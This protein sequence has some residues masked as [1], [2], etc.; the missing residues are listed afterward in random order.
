MKLHNKLY[1]ITIVL[2]IVMLFFPY[3]INA[4]IEYNANGEVNTDVV[5]T[6]IEDDNLVVKIKKSVAFWYYLMRLISISVMLLILLFTGIKMAISTVASEKAMYKRMLTDWVVGMILVFSI[7]YIMVAIINFNEMLV[8]VL[9]NV[10]IGS[11]SESLSKE[12]NLSKYNSAS[13]IEIS[14]YEAVRT[15]AYDA[16]LINGTTGMVMYMFLVYYAVKFTIMYLK[17][18]LT[19]VVL[20]LMAP[21]VSTSYAI[22]KIMTGKSKIFSTWLTEYFMNVII[23]TVHALVY[24]V[25][26]STAIVISL[27]SIS[28]MILALVLL[29]FMSKAEKLF[30][31]IFKLSDSA[32]AND[33]AENTGIKQLTDAFKAGKQ[34]MIGGEIAKGI[35]KVGMKAV[36]KPLKMVGTKAFSA[37]MVARAKLK[38][39]KGDYDSQ[40]NDGTI[41]SVSENDVLEKRIKSKLDQKESIDKN[42]E[43]IE[44]DLEDANKKRANNEE[45]QERY[46]E[47]LK[48]K[49]E[50]EKKKKKVDG[51]IAVLESDQIRVRDV[52]KAK[53][54]NLLDPRHYVENRRGKLRAK[55]R[56][57]QWVT[58]KVFA[59]E[60]KSNKQG[61]GAIL[62]EQLSAQ[63]LFGMSDKDKEFLKQGMGLIKSATLGFLGCMV[64]LPVMID[65]PS[66]GLP[67]LAVGMHNSGKLFGRKISKRVYSD[68]GKRRY[69]WG[70]Y[71]IPKRYAAIKTIEQQARE[72]AENTRDEFIVDNIRKRHSKLY[73]LLVG[74]LATVAFI[75]KTMLRVATAVPIGM[76]R[77]FGTTTSDYM[78]S[79]NLQQVRQMNKQIK[80]LREEKVRMIEKDVFALVE[81]AYEEY[82][83]SQQERIDEIDQKSDEQILK[84]TQI[85]EGN[86]IDI[87]DGCYVEIANVL[88]DYNDGQ[89]EKEEEIDWIKVEAEI[90]KQ[91]KQ[92]ESL[93]EE[94]AG[95]KKLATEETEEHVI[96]SK[97]KVIKMKTEGI[98]KAIDDA[99]IQVS[100]EK[101]NLD[102]S[103][104][105][106]DDQSTRS[107]VIG[108]MSQILESRGLKDSNLDLRSVIQDYDSQLRD[109]KAALDKG[110]SSAVEQRI[111]TDAIQEVMKEKKIKNPKNMT[112]DDIIQVVEQANARRDEF[113]D[114]SK[115]SHTKKSEGVIQRIQ[116]QRPIDMSEEKERKVASSLVDMVQSVYANM[117]V[118]EPIKKETHSELIQE[119]RERQKRIILNEPRQIIT[120]LQEKY[121]G[122]GYS[123]TGEQ[124]GDEAVSKKKRIRMPDQ[125]QEKIEDKPRE[126]L[127]HVLDIL[128]ENRREGLEVKVELASSR[129]KKL[130]RMEM[131]IEDLSGDRKVDIN[132]D[133]TFDT[134]RDGSIKLDINRDGVRRIDSRKKPNVDDIINLM[135]AKTKKS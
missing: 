132:G 112:A 92:E 121:S 38:G 19:I 70:G 66:V 128:L 79:V 46:T 8:S 135:Y 65:N 14:L 45:E 82:R 126:D 110:K 37:A 3:Y 99:I 75:P 61:V 64:G 13:D 31:K 69:T 43:Q 30:R 42:L 72:E 53:M 86:W 125:I 71:S 76:A 105:S 81:T 74:G 36:T 24:T 117:Q 108:T 90:R 49:R 4:A 33:M 124:A 91:Y 44:R 21:A 93:P 109:R 62:R 55:K 68:T 60:A 131:P 120:H 107:Q 15:R 32:L 98:S 101:G 57:T 78:H 11:V 47:L 59:R 52:F 41:S 100:I 104:M 54:S 116:R 115:T 16:K 18:Y 5:G 2:L 106:L 20:T 102:I 27:N 29:N 50:I 39:E 103:T 118:I 23:Q 28:G 34:A 58:G 95:K 84:E 7:H 73:K 133:R 48:Q 88:V 127:Q 12:F 17:R 134:S 83:L 85:A 9:S 1:K 56:E 96:S 25:F 10:K 122:E 35:Q 113:I 119:L 26:V 89:E 40:N 129:D 22:N 87:G 94:E 80:K 6:Q 97:F 51:D 111:V 123:A 77:N 63:N 130:K 67:I 114:K